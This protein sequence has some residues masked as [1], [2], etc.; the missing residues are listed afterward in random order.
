MN[1]DTMHDIYLVSG[2]GGIRC[3]FLSVFSVACFDA[4]GKKAIKWCQWCLGQ[5]NGCK[6][7]YLLEWWGGRAIGGS[8]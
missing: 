4:W 7:I 8:E 1:F 5:A 3:A 2:G 6:C